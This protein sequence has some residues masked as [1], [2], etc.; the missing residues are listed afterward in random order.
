MKDIL[1]HYDTAFST[2]GN[3]ENALSKTYQISSSP[4]GKDQEGSRWDGGYLT[5]IMV[6][7]E[8]NKQIDI[9]HSNRLWQKNV[10][11]SKTQ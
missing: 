9:T 3:I 4:V 6:I 2:E 5:T 7:P 11:V 1:K 10:G 8:S